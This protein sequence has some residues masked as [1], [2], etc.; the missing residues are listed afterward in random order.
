MQKNKHIYKFNINT[1]ILNFNYFEK[2]LVISLLPLRE[3]SKRRKISAKRYFSDSRKGNNEITNF[4]I[5]FT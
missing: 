4:F 1:F 2:K 5:A 3:F